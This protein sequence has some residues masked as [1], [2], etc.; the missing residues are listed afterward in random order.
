MVA[1]HRSLRFHLYYTILYDFLP[2]HNWESCDKF[3]T[4]LYDT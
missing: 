2:E 1:C 3:N 4:L